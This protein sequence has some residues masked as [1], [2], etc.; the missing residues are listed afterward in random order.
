[1]KRVHDN[2]KSA[3]KA[4]RGELK[5]KFP[6]IK[7]SVRSTQRGTSS[8]DIGW[9]DGPTAEQVAAVTGKYELGSFDGMTDCYVYDPT[10]VVAE[11]GEI[12]ELGGARYVFEHRHIS[13][14][15]R[16]ACRVAC[17]GYWADWDRLA[18][19]ER[20]ERIYRILYKS[21]LRG[22]AASKLQYADNAGGAVLVSA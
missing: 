3:A 8:I 20:D 15:A 22:V 12:M 10:H 4:I 16:E 7:F 5:A 1:M 2:P 18:G 21:D 13:D 11:D 9:T 6:G 19:Y 17:E 14:E